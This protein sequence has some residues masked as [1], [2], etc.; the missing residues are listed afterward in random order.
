M[1]FMDHQPDGSIRHR[2]LEGL[3]E[4]RMN[5]LHEGNLALSTVLKANL[6]QY[7]RHSVSIAPL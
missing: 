3:H 5:G 6:D 7:C 4:R 1:W 2:N